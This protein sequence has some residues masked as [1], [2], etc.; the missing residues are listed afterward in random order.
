[1]YRDYI[2]AHKYF[3]SVY[4]QKSFHKIRFYLEGNLS[5]LSNILEME[6]SPGTLF[7]CLYDLFGSF[8]DLDDRGVDRE[9][10]KG[11][12][13]ELYEHLS[14]EAC[15]NLSQI[16]GCGSVSLGVLKSS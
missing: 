15:E 16:H 7:F 10:H 3:L 1:M 11:F 6:S 8:L 12:F 9:I 5:E 2:L 14:R 13:T 4:N